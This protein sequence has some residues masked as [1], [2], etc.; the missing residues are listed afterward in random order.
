MVEYYSKKRELIYFKGLELSLHSTELEV[1]RTCRQSPQAIGDRSRSVL[2]ETHCVANDVAVA[3]LRLISELIYF[4][5]VELSLHSTELE[6]KR[7]CRQSP[8]Q[9]EIGP[10]VCF[11]ETHCVANDV[12]VAML[13]LISS[14]S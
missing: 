12:A 13:R 14:M 4:K 6:V 2:C 7:T 3:M 1:K 10:G 8:K 9:L 5:G 11:C